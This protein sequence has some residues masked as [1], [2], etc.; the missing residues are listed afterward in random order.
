MAGAELDA[1]RVRFAEQRVEHVARAIG[2]GEQLAA[3]LFVEPDAD[4]LEERD[5]VGNREGAQDPADNRSLSTPEVG[6]GHRR[7]RDVAPGAAADEDFRAR[8]SGA[9]EE[10]NRARLV[11]GGG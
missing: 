3:G 10:Q 2:I 7:V 8:L 9:V 4:P 1:A 5:R 6:V 11:A